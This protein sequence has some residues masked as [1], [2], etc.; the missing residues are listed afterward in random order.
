MAQLRSI[1][2]IIG[3]CFL[4]AGCNGKKGK[5]KSYDNPKSGTIHI[6]VDESFK[7]VISEQIKVYESSY[8]DAHI[9]PEYKS[10]ADCLKDI[11]K[12]S[13]R[14]IIISRGLTREESQFFASRLNYSPQFDKLAYDA[15]TVIINSQSTDSVFSLKK[16]ESLLSG[17]QPGKQLVVDGNNATSTVMFLKDSVLKGKSF[18]SNV[19]AV[20]GSKAVVEY[21]ANN[22][23]AIGFVGSSWVGNEE[24]PEQ[25]AYAGKIRFAL[26]ECKTCE[27][28]T[29]AKPSPA[30]VMYKQYPLVRP[31][32]YVLKEN[33]TGLG[34]AF[35][36]FMGF[37]RGQL[38]FRRAYLVPAKINFQIRSGSIKNE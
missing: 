33:Y 28:G 10:E 4:L 36:G 20:H 1:G 26:I 23:D 21:V 13:T 22:R 17:A 32:F 15:V 35:A 27:P 30:T 12:D 19:K 37:E 31:L 25:L 16:L 38:I 18:G 29:Y 7:P 24:D 14:M 11:Q 2:L 8:P 5:I 3:F 6:S 34:S 9:I